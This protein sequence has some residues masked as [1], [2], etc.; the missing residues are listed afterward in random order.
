[1]AKEPL[2]FNINLDPTFNAVGALEELG[3]K[4]F[5][6]AQRRA[7]ERSAQLIKTKMEEFLL[8]GR[9]EW[10]ENHPIT[11]SMKGFNWPLMETGQ[12]AQSITITTI[13]RGSRIDYLIG[14]PPGPAA[15]KA[16]NA[17]FGK[18]IV[19]TDR[20]RRFMAANGFPL[21]S[22][23][24]VLFIPPRQLF[25]PAFDESRKEVQAAAD[26]ELE[27]TYSENNL[28]GLG[29]GSKFAWLRNQLRNDRL[30]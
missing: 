12:L 19:V 15:D 21:K 20:M 6:D 26:D 11:V 5:K 10:P 27:K 1:V 23:T 14:F 3:V 22:D 25:Q 8:E 17:E 4:L 28:E 24:K 30:R 2:R 16:L 29:G 9:A 7:G 13:E 18:T